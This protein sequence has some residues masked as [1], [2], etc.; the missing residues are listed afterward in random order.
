M[1][2]N[3]DIN[4]IISP[5]SSRAKVKSIHQQHPDKQHK[6]FNRQLREEDENN[7]EE[8]RK[9]RFREID[10][11]ENKAAGMLK[12]AGDEDENSDTRMDKL[13]EMQ[14]ILLDIIV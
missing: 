4:K 6:K 2:D 1:I 10:S 14:G 7:R 3:V 9:D 13:N 12:I 8:K 5:V 11:V